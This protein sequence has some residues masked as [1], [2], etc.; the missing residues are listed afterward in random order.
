MEEIEKEFESRIA[1]HLRYIFYC[2][3]QIC[4]Q[5]SIYLIFKFFFF[6]SLYFLLFLILLPQLYYSQCAESARVLMK[7]AMAAL[8]RQCLLQS[9]AFML[10]VVLLVVYYNMCINIYFP[11]S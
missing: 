3:T 6:F 9:G 7:D 5:S 8:N 2:N 4:S 1:I 10:Q 11:R